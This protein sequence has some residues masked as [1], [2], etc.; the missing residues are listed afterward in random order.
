MAKNLSFGEQQ[1][2]SKFRDLVTRI[3]RKVVQ[4]ERPAE[5]VGR[6]LVWNSANMTAQ[7]IF[8]GDDITNP[9]RVKYS[10]GM[11]PVLA[12]VQNLVTLGMD[13]PSD[14]VRIAGRPG[15]YYIAGYVRG[16]PA[17]VRP[18]TI[19]LWPTIDVPEGWLICDGS[20]VPVSQYSTLHGVM[21]YSHGGTGEVF[22]LPN[23]SAATLGA[24]GT[25]FMIK[26]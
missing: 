19:C 15:S 6:V 25:V 17:A 11:A 22:N 24:G 12:M 4:E 14:I 5:R 26:T 8:P 16:G 7:V 10:E 2:A 9:T 23:L 21:G 13:A 1:Y 20:E 18:G 3:A